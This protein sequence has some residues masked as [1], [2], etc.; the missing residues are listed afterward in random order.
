MAIAFDVF[1]ESA[2]PHILSGTDNGKDNRCFL[3]MHMDGYSCCQVSFVRLLREPTLLTFA[4]A[5]DWVSAH[6][7]VGVSRIAFERCPPVDEQV[8]D[9][10][11]KFSAVDVDQEM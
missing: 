7:P 5:R 4:G 9:Q 3:Q 6:V 10:N 8:D 1:G 2:S 11:S